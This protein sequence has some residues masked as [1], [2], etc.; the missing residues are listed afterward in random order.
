M[1]KAKYATLE[2]IPENYRDLFEERG[3]EWILVKIEGLRSEADVTRVQRSLD[4]EKTSHRT[5]K[6]K[7]SK[8]DNLDPDEVH[9]KLQQNEEL[10]AQLDASGDSTDTAKLDKVVETKVERATKPLQ[11]ALDAAKQNVLD[12][13]ASNSELTQKES[14]RLI[15]DNVREACLKAKIRPEAIEDILVLAP[16]IFERADDG[17]ILVKGEADTVTNYLEDMREKRPHWWPTS[18]GGDAGDTG[19][20]GKGFGINPFT[21]V[22]WNVTA[23]AALVKDKGLPYAEKLAKA[24]GTY[25]GGSCPKK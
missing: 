1:L 19:G 2:D 12:L 4:Q 18:V 13:T 17:A 20:K 22:N 6:D 3:G 23:Q 15:T 8:F 11:R 9:D 14:T 5:T 10:R 25:V 7:L 24:A 21:A 16:H